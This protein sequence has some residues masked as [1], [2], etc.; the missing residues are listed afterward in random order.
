MGGPR[1][2]LAAALL[3]VVGASACAAPAAA[4]SRP[5]V[6]ASTTVLADLVANVA[7]DRLRV[8]SL[9]PAG[10]H[11]EEYAPSPDD[12]ARVARAKLVVLNGLGLDRWS[13]RLVRSGGTAR[14]V[15][16]SEGLPTLEGNPHLWFDV[17]LARRYVAR[18][19]DELTTL[20]PPGAD[21]FAARARDYDARL[22]ALDAE[23]KA[24]V[25][26]LPEARGKLVTSHDAF[27][28]FARA[29]GFTI[30]GFAELEAG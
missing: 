1:L 16:L 29:F 21:T 5:L 24:K 19:R 26:T 6:L 20:D 30:V 25:A 8:E 9:V 2:V 10:V 27:P 18:V 4:P 22:A 11:V 23:L 14:V 13:D 12:A 17:A 3:A 7:G 28:Y 15:T